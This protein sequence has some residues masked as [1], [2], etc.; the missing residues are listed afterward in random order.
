MTLLLKNYEQVELTLSANLFNAADGDV[1]TQP[2]ITGARGYSK[3]N[4]SLSGNVLVVT[5]D[6]AWNDL[7]DSTGDPWETDGT[8]P[9]L[10][11]NGVDSGVKPTAKGPST[12]IIDNW[13]LRSS[14][15]SQFLNLDPTDDYTFTSVNITTIERNSDVCDSYL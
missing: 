14:N 11:V 9:N 10:F 15:S 13:F 7:D 5:V 12:E 1:I 3:G 2:G 6:G 4:Y 8:A